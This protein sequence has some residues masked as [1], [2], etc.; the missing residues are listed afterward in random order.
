MENGIAVLFDPDR[1]GMDKCVNGIFKEAWWCRGAHA[2][3]LFGALF[4]AKPRINLDRKRLELPDG[5]F[6]DL[7]FLRASPQNGRRDVPLVIIL[8]GLE[9]SSRAPY[10]QAL[11]GSIY[12][13][14]WDSVAINM[15]TCSGVPNRLKQT[16]H[17]GKTEDL[18]WV[19]ND[20][21]EKEKCGK[22]Y[23]VGY[24]IGGNILL[25]WLGE[26]GG[27]IPRGVQ[28]AVA[29]SVPYDLTVSVQLMD[30]GF[31][32]RIYTHALLASLKA[33]IRM[34]EKQFPAAIRYDLAKR[35][36]TFKEF[37]GRVTAPLNGFRDEVDYWIKTSCK[38]FLE[39]IAVPTLLIHAEDDPFFPGKLLP[40]DVI[41]RSKY[42]KSLIVPH[43]G[44]LGFVAGRWPWKQELWIERKIMDFFDELN[45]R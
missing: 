15:R 25:K 6:L 21:I 26:R 27:A 34:K 33:K 14:G 18:E 8:H 24:S 9:G 30:R 38:H 32:R 16:Y 10:V 40:A 1:C 41:R 22:I 23:L 35:S 28:K 43:G 37:D 42:L 20:F 44:H 4:R 45:R 31:N 13:A 11:L 36:A 3:T 12:A 39:S 5:D 19:V 29:I 7:D 17:S 2:Q